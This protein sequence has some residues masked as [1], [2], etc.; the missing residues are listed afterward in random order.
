MGSAGKNGRERNGAGRGQ[1]SRAQVVLPPSVSKK[2]PTLIVIGGREDKIGDALILREVVRHVADG[3]LVATAVASNEPESYFEEYDRAFR[4]LGMTNI[5][6]LEVASRED[7]TNPKVLSVFEGANA[8][9]FTGGDQLKIT[10]QIGGTPVYDRIRE[11][12]N[13]GGVIAGTSAGASVV[14]GTMLA[15]GV[16]KTS[17]RLGESVQMAPGLGFIRNM[18]IDQHFAERGRM[19]RLLAAVAQNPRTLGLGIDENTAVVIDKSESFYVVGA[20]AVY[21]VDGRYISYSN[22]TESAADKT[23]AVYD[24]KLHVLTEGDSFDL[25]TRRPA[26]FGAI[27]H[28]RTLEAAVSASV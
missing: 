19:G 3:K 20:G 1:T 9:F 18:I 10:S 23:L 8:V 22:V 5:A 26:S 2:R 17:P 14:C 16:G 25:K 12:Y 28:I 7:A 4:K 11:I 15:A 13:S 6:H 24:V 27:Q 21:A